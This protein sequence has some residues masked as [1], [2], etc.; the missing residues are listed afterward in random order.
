MVLLM[1]MIFCAEP[2]SLHKPDPA[3]EAEYEAAK[4]VGFEVDLIDFEALV[5]DANV[6]RALRKVWAASTEELGIYRGWMLTVAQ[7]AQLFAGLQA[8]GIRLINS[9]GG[10]QHCHHLPESYAVIKSVTPRTTW[11]R[12]ADKIDFSV[13]SEALAVFGNQPIIVKDFVKSRKHE[14]D[15]ACFI[16]AASNRVALESVVN[17]FLELQGEQ[18]TEGLVFRE[19]V[20]FEALAAHSKSGMPLTKEYR[21]F[22][23]DGELLQAFEYW[24]EGD[25]GSSILPPD[26]FRE[27]VPN[28]R[29][30]FFTMDV[31]RR[32]EGDWMI[33]E[34]GDGQVAGL[35]EAADATSFY[36]AVKNQLT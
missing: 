15:E 12:L 36:G 18:L 5:D 27:V 7:Y 20:E 14:W 17:R 21:L 24:G 13:L 4:Q 25:Y 26:L 19:F 29:S 34:L 23:L 22:W 3:Y 9:P 10:Y 6:A 8:K 1:R 28:V 11:I 16:P 32:K 30:R 2:F 31:A 33:V 35:P